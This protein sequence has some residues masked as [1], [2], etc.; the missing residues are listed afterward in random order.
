MDTKKILLIHI[1]NVSGHRC[2]GLAIDK[3]L[4]EISKG[5]QTKSIDIFSYTNPLI[6]KFI[7]KL[8]TI[9]IKIAPRIWDYLYDN[10]QIFKKARKIRS[11]IHYINDKKINKLLT[12]FK[13][14]IVVCTQA[15]PCGMIADY[16]SRH[17]LQIPLIGVLTDFAPHR[18]WLNN[19]IDFYIVPALKIKQRLMQRGIPSTRIKLLGIPI[20]SRFANQ[21]KKEEIFSKLKLN[22]DIPVILIMGGG[23]GL[24]PIKQIVQTLNRITPAVQLIVVCGTNRSLYRWLKRKQMKFK[25]FISIMGYTEYINELMDISSLIVTKPGGLTSAEALSKSLPIIII[26]PLPGQETQN[27]HF[28]LE[29]GVALQA[30]D[31]WQ[32]K[33]LVEDLLSNAPKLEQLR[34]NACAIACADSSRKIAQFIFSILE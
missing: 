28:L 22:P 15:F 14:D 24:G 7:N 20:D 6:G 32:L 4:K 11:I 8:Y 33:S 19:N 29:S 12:K 26:N 9:V 1:S 18:Y 21:S 34:K 13:P 16:K 5:L 27:M 17:N 2:A 23:Q 10:E 31:F 30:L 3:A 25:Q